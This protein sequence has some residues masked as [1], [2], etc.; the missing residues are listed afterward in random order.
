MNVDEY[1]T[2]I[3]DVHINHSTQVV[4]FIGRAHTMANEQERVSVEGKQAL[5][6]VQH[7]VIGNENSP[8]NTWKI[9]YLTSNSKNALINRF[10]LMDEY[11]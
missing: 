9:V 7:G 11:Q 4:T 10:K 3:E 8:Q 5:F 1:D 6:H 2:V